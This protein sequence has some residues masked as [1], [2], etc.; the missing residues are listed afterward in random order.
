VASASTPTSKVIKASREALYQAFLDPAALVVWLPPEETTGEIYR[1][2]ARVGG[3]YPMSL[4]YPSS[5]QVHRGKSSDREDSFT[6][7]FVELTPPV[8]IVQAVSLHSADPA[9]SGEMT[10]E[11]T[12]EVADGAT[13]VTIVCTHLPPGIRPEDNEAGC[14]SSLYKLACYAEKEGGSSVR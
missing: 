5:E 11:A 10:F 7:R 3:E 14:R 6:A 1:F 9:F 2:D 8:R 12:L 13:E 4:F